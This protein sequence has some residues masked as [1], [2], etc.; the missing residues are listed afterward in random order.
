[1]R[2]INSPCKININ[3][4]FIYIFYT[5]LRIQYSKSDQL[6]WPTSDQC[7]N[8]SNLYKYWSRWIKNPIT[9]RLYKDTFLR[10]L[11]IVSA[12]LHNTFCGCLALSKVMVSSN[13]LLIY[14]ATLVV[15]EVLGIK[16]LFL[17]TLTAVSILLINLL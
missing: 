13:W 10:V 4:W 8:W 3:N 17:L 16:P 15:L 1:M 7:H 9:W 12:R 5:F 2:R 6:K 14:S 11:S